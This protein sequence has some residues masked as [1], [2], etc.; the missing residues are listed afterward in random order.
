MQNHE[1][2]ALG[3]LLCWM[4]FETFWDLRARDH[5]IPVW[6]SLA[7]VLPGLAWLGFYVSPWAAILMT[8]SIVSTEI[9]PR[10]LMLGFIGLFAP[11]PLAVLISPSL[12][13]LA[14][15]WAVLLV[16]WFL[17][18]LGGADALAALALLLFFPSWTMATAILLG[19]FCWNFALLLRKYRKD[20]GRRLWAVLSS[21]APGTMEAGLG[22]YALA[23]LFYSVYRLLGCGL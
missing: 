16:L 18:V 23:V 6:F 22:A 7:T 10:Y 19:I 17:N 8:I 15:G 11:P 13:P 4:V 1:A 3:Y 5:T 9:Y 21:R 2:I 14:I 20:V 12:L